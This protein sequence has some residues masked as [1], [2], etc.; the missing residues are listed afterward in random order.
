MRMKVLLITKIRKLTVWYVIEN[1]FT[2]DRW[3]DRKK[4]TA[5]NGFLSLSFQ[6]SKSKDVSDFVYNE[7]PRE[8]IHIFLSL[9]IMLCYLHWNIFLTRFMTLEVMS[10][11]SRGYT[12]IQHIAYHHDEK[13]EKLLFH[14]P[15][16]WRFWFSRN[17]HF[18]TVW[19]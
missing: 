5:I 6:L 14:S 2:F 8:S 12:H 4:T 10:R 7:T 17:R 18:V 11:M 19:S 1:I 13:I 9:K 3:N 15:I 16:T